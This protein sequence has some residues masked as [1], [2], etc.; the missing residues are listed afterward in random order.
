MMTKMTDCCLFISFDVSQDTFE[1]N[2]CEYVMLSSYIVWLQS[3]KHRGMSDDYMRIR[4][5]ETDYLVA[6]A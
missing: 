2:G 6:Y 4:K 1:L 3:Q 5:G